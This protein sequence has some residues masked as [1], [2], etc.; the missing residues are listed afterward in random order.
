MRLLVTSAFLPWP[1]DNGYKLRTLSLLQGLASLGHEVT[2]LAFA[3]PT[4][5]ARD[6]AALEQWCRRVEVVPMTL[7]SLSSAGGYLARLG[8]L[9]SGQP[10]SARRFRAGDMERRIRDWLD[11][12]AGDAVIADGVF[13]L[14]NVPATSVP[15]L[16]NAHNVEHV[17]LERYARHEGSPL[18]RLYARLE[19]RKLRAFERAA[20]GR[21]AV[22]M[23]CSEVDRGH[24]GRLRPGR[25]QVVVPN[26]VD[27]DG[28]APVAGGDGDTVLFQG[29][30]DWYPNRDAVAF[31]VSEVLPRVRRAWPAARLIVAGRNPSDAF[32]RRWTRHGAVEFTGTVDDMRP[33][34]A[35]AALS[36]VPLRIGSGTRLK[37]LEAAA[38][39]RAVVSTRLGA[40]GLA[41]VEAE[42][43]VLA[44]EP[45]AFADAVVGLLADRERRATLGRAARR[46]VEAEYSPRV[47]AQQL[48]RALE[49]VVRPA[50]AA[51][52]RHTPRWEPVAP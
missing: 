20:C 32:R 27:V 44:D 25:P 12:S 13:C 34:I 35:R 37:I 30:L 5:A 22:V 21:S 51:R 28:Y 48:R 19:A 38:M 47:V 8:S 15:V 33:L 49:H 26:V 45:Q 23:P 42:E 52:A 10:F 50:P 31:F 2:L 24:L 40:E 18:K 6:H 43:I 17:I 41:F 16:L 9:A 11:T 3:P 29:G 46:R 4:E 1:A 39:E 14:V 36:V 7:P